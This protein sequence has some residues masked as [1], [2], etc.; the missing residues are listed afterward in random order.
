MK[1]VYGVVL[2]I[3]FAFFTPLQA[4]AAESDDSRQDKLMQDGLEMLRA[5]KPQAAIEYFDNVIEFYENKYRDSKQRVYVAQSPMESI[6]LSLG[7]ALDKQPAQVI[8]GPWS[9][10]YYY[11]GYA[12]IEL[13][14]MARAKAALERAIALTPTAAMFLSELG[15]VYQAEKDWNKAL[16]IFGEAEKVSDFSA[17]PTRAKGRALRGIGFSLIK[18]G[19]LD[20]AS[21]AFERALTLDPSDAKAKNEMDYI[22]ALRKKSYP[23]AECTDSLGG[24]ICPIHGGNGVCRG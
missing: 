24:S 20:Q 6:H 9:Y 13:N 21:N 15:H 10:A 18:L 12:L 14:E 8:P 23:E 4:N 19:K 16:T 17:D 1:T 22:A 3:W 7:A 5:K 11:K 2:A